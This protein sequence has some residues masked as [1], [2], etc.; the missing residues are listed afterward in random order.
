MLFG[1]R[2]P[3]LVNTELFLKFNR[4]EIERFHLL[5]SILTLHWPASFAVCKGEKNGV[6]SPIQRP[7]LHKVH[8]F[9]VKT[10]K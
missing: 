2:Y 4:N 1:S 3:V 9:V 10:S 6:Q 7:R 5:C 8:L